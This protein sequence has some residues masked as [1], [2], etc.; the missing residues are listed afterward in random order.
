[1]TA[2]TAR[3]FPR[4]TH[5]EFGIGLIDAGGHGS[6]SGRGQVEAGPGAFI[7]VNP[8]EVHD[9]R[10]LGRRARS[11]RILYIEPGLLADLLEDVAG[12]GATFEFTRPAFA[13]PRLRAPFEAAF[14]HTHGGDAL[15]CESAML[16]L[17]AGLRSH[18]GPPS[19]HSFRAAPDLHR[20]R[21]R[22]DACPAAA[23]TLSE[24]AREC[25]LSRFQFL[26]AFAR[27]F[28]LPPHAYLVQRRLACARRLLRAHVP[29]AEVAARTGFS[30]QSHLTRCFSR[31]FGISPA[32]YAALR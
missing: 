10:A 28:A 16:E 25:S 30:D 15:S 1:M 2:R 26:R 11:W 22:L 17:V 13:D 19:R 9:G 21:E 20:A 8:G 32:R 6:L 24:L 18:A 23:I 27:A 3:S 31:Q 5:D 4:H 7:S 29:S 12:G 14:A